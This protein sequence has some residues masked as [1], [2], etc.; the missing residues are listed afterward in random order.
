[1]LDAILQCGTWCESFLNGAAHQLGQYAVSVLAG[2][3]PT[4]GWSWYV[5]ASER[6]E[7]E[8]RF[9]EDGRRRAAAF[10]NRQP[11]A[12]GK[13][14]PLAR[15]FNEELY[16]L[17]KGNSL[18]KFKANGLPAYFWNQLDTLRMK[19]PEDPNVLK[20]FGI[21]DGAVTDL[22]S[23]AESRTNKSKAHDELFEIVKA[24]YEKLLVALG[25]S[26]TKEDKEARGRRTIKTG[27]AALILAFFWGAPSEEPATGDSRGAVT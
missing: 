6:R 23:L 4:L 20:T 13:F 11:E 27:A 3:F 18:R 15:T 14:L 22:L 10:E 24:A 26:V 9:V 21:Y 12:I 19:V 7:Q 1:M 17:L 8:S 16:K 25:D 2:V 5:R